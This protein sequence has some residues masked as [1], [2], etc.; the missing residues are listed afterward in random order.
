MWVLRLADAGKRYVKYEDVPLLVT[1]LKLRARSRR[2]E[3]WAVRHVDLDVEQGETVGIIGRNGS[4]KSTTLRMLAGV[5]APTEGVVSVRGRVAPLISVGVGFHPEL[6]GR[7]NV[8]VNG[9][10]LGMS[11]SE[12]DAL[13]DSIVSFAELEQFIDTPIKFYSS[14]MFVRLGFSVAVAA[15]PDLLLV[16]EVLA[17]GDLAFQAKCFDRM[18]EIKGQGTSVLVVSHNLN[19]IRRLCTRTLVLHDGATKFLGDTD[20]AIGAYQELLGQP[21]QRDK[22]ATASAQ[23]EILDFRLLG[24]DGAPSNHL[25]NDDEAVFQMDVVFHEGSRDPVFAFRLTTESGQAVYG[26]TTVRSK[27][28]GYEAGERVR[29]NIVMRLPLVTGSYT[30][31]AS[32]GSKENEDARTHASPLHFFI[33]GRPRV[34]G[35]ADLAAIFDVQPTSGEIRARGEIE[36]GEGVA[37]LPAV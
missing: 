29:C 26:E 18:E 33:S 19:S 17:V 24:P 28:Q 13:F 1:R 6:T 7:E 11:R 27:L 3:L 25:K 16:D 37:G 34:K 35:V 4:G 2:D 14:G 9:I 20:S 21:G 36:P 5:T 12:V 30:A 23:I 8:Y 22:K 32:V 15:R 31:R 10:I